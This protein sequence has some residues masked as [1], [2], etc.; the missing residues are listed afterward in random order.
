[1]TVI[2]DTHT[3]IWFLNND[4]DLSVT[5]RR[6]IEDVYVN[7]YVSIMS[8]WEMV[9]KAAQG[10]LIMPVSVNELSEVLFKINIQILPVSLNDLKA[11]QSLPFH[12]K[13]PFDRILIAQGIATGFTI[14]TVDPYFSKY[15]IK[16]LW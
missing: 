11:Y 13:D 12:H 1:M 7:C 14:L 16:L 15:G 9:L 10:K 4:T 5:A 6:M 3:L 8:L 2:L